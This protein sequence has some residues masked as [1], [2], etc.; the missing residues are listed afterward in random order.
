MI[1]LVLWLAVHATYCTSFRD[2]VDETTC[3]VYRVGAREV[4]VCTYPG[5]A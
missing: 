4:N 2:S 3:D 1:A 5:G